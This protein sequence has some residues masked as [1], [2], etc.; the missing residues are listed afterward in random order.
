MK[1]LSHLLLGLGCLTIAFLTASGDVDKVLHFPDPLNEMGFFLGSGMLG[2][3]F[4]AAF[5]MTDKKPKTGL[6]PANRF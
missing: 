3:M 2:I 1:K 6:D 5:F 4:I